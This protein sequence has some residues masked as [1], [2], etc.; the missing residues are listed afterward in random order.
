MTCLH[1]QRASKCTCSLEATVFLQYFPSN[2]L[3][4]VLN[5]CYNSKPI[6]EYLNYFKDFMC[7][8]VIYLLVHSS[9]WDVENADVIV[10]VAVAVIALF[11]S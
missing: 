11:R 1:T 3:E 4:V 10:A 6:E 7:V 2:L 5:Q 8:I 9:S